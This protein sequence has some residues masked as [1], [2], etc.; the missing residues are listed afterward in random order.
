MPSIKTYNQQTTTSGAVASRERTAAD[1]GGNIG[2]ALVGVGESLV[3]GG[4]VIYKVREKDEKTD[5]SIKLSQIQDKYNRGIKD[6]LSQYDPSNDTLPSAMEDGSIPEKKNFADELM[7]EYDKEIAE[8]GSNI[9]TNSAKD[10]LNINSN[11]MRGQFVNTSMAAQVEMASLKSKE[12]YSK[13]RNNLSSSVRTDPTSFDVAKNLHNAQV[14]NFIKDGGDR[15]A[16]TQLRLEGERDLAVSTVRGWIDLNPALAKKQLESGAYDPYLPGNTRDQMLGEIEQASNGKLI[17]DERAKRLQKEEIETRRSQTQNTLIE[18]YANGE[19]TVKEVLASND[20]EAFGSGSK[21]QFIKML[22]SNAASPVKK[23]DTQVYR[24]LWDR[25]NLPD[26]NPQKLTDPNELNA[27][28]GRGITPSTLKFF[29]DEISGAK[30][31]EGKV[32]AQLKSGLVDIAKNQLTRSNPLTGIKDPT[33]DENLQRYMSTMLKE[34]NEQRAKGKSAYELLSPESPD[35]LGKTIKNYVRSQKQIM[36]D[37]V[38]Q[39]KGGSNPPALV[40]PEI[41]RADG[42]TAAQFLARLKAAKAGTK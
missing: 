29:R 35:Y 27:F 26:G 12:A 24:S 42:E 23:D 3:K 25:I 20:L 11:N 39:A 30:T 40:P 28:V 4:E 18:K 32:E 34:Y 19:L 38:K 33:G 31:P 36:S 9:T 8:L 22:S 41:V 10:F 16:A 2:K 1:Y 21:D 5:L 6:K 15:A 17:D 7:S 13:T 37:Y 14:E